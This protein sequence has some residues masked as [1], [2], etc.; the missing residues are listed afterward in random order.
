MKDLLKRVSRR[1]KELRSNFL[2]VVEMIL[3]C[4]L[5]QSAQRESCELSFIWG[6]MKTAAMETAP[7]TVLRNC[8]KEGGGEGQYICNFRE[9]GV[10]E[11]KHIL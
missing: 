4:R 1:V 5:E 10:H 6:H 3:Y 2:V 9:E 8:S 11:I 7:Q